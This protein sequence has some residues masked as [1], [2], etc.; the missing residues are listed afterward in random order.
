VVLI[1]L[2]TRN[3][4]GEQVYARVPATFRKVNGQWMIDSLQIGFGQGP[5]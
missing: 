5:R 3:A 2:S 1:D 4:N